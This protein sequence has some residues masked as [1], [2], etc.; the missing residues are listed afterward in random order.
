MFYLALLKIK[1]M[2]QMVGLLS[3]FLLFLKIMGKDMLEVAEYSKK[4][5]FMLC[6][7]NSTFITLIPKKDN[8]N[9]FSDF[10]PIALCNMVYKMV[11]KVIAERLKPKL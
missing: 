2:V 7:L 1:V 5:G 9:S 8:P 6:S 10:R 3:C 4:E 11:T